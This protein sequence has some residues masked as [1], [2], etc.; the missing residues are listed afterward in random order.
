MGFLKKNLLFCIVV[1]LCVAAS[2]VGVVLALK[3]SGQVEQ[4]QRSLTSVEAQLSTLLKADPAPTEDN[5]E[6]A[7]RNLAELE[8]ALAQIRKDLQSG[9]SLSTS[10][11]GVSVMAGI[12]QYIS[13]FQKEVASHKDEAGEP[14][15]I[16]TPEDFAFGFEEYIDEA[17][18]LQDPAKVTLLDKQRQILSYLL[19]QL[20]AADP[21]SIDSVER[22]VVESEGE[23]KSN[24]FSIDPL[25]SAR[26]PGAID[27]MAFSLT[28]SGYTDSLR[29]L[30]NRLADF[31]LPI[32]VRSIKVK[33]PSGSE[34]VVAPPSGGGAD[35]IFALFEQGGTP[36]T[37]EEPPAEGPE[38]V[39]EE[40]I[41]KFTVILEF[42]EVVLPDTQ[43]QEVSDP[44]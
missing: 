15:R 7:E 24:S 32:V 12:Q 20:I 21:H 14:D 8:I 40:N 13:K 42:I 31:D 43:P 18:M 3:A 19:T 10:A 4:A 23:K 36:S 26:V 5:L 37:V 27:T 16:E 34:T 29:E 39:I 41:S 22:E 30:L 33:R 2:I 28:F 44:A 17:A 6:A 38:P 9:A 25:I 35:D 11:D 1:T